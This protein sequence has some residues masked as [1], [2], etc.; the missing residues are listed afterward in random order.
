[1]HR[2]GFIF[3]F[4]IGLTVTLISLTAIAAELPLEQI[5]LPPGFVLELW[6]R[7]DNA[8]Q[9]TLGHHD[10]HGGTIFVGSMKAGKV[11]A[12][13]FG[14]DSKVQDIT[15]IAHGLK[16]PAGVAYREGSLYVSAVSQILRYDEIERH[17]NHPPV[18]VVVTDKLPTEVSM[19]GNS[20]PSARTVSSTYRLAHPAISAILTPSTMQTFYV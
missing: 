19:D 15:I 6:A 17:L 13:S 18:A 20:S 11:Y 4:I 5:K 3:S 9:M 10:T 12:V 14:V 16:L 1:M 8:R 2:I 7:V